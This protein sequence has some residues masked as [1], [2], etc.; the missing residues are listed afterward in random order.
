MIDKL[1]PLYTPSK[2]ELADYVATEQRPLFN[3][4]CDFAEIK[5]KAKPQI[6]YS[7]CTAIPGW[8]LKYKKSS[9]SVFTLYPFE[10][11]FIAMITMNFDS[12]EIF[13]VIKSDFSTKMQSFIEKTSF[14]N[15]TK[16]LLIDVKDKND[17]NEVIMLLNIKFSLQAK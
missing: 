16:W 9:K 17:L 12:L 11:K 2:Q 4:L 10:D 15:G 8:N 1:N 7:K 6:D 14:F 13:N 5:L 3:E